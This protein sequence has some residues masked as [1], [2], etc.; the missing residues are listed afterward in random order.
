V[1]PPIDPSKSSHATPS[2]RLSV[3]TSPSPSLYTS[4]A[5]E[6]WGFL[7][8]NSENRDDDLKRE[9]AQSNPKPKGE[10]HFSKRLSIT[11]LIESAKWIRQATVEDAEDVDEDSILIDINV[12]SIANSGPNCEDKS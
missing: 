1:Q 4:D 7:E 2:A 5:P 9:D 12:Q 3:P 8:V 10:Y 6:K 11:H